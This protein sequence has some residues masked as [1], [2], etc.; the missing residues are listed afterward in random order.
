MRWVDPSIE[1]VLCGSSGNTM[2]TFPAWEETVLDHCYEQVDYLSLHKYIGDPDK[3][4]ARFLAESIGMDEFISTV[5]ATCDFVKAKKRSDKT[6][7]L[8]FDEWNVWYHSHSHDAALEPWSVAPV[9]SKIITLFSM[10]L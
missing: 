2:D 1:L 3:N 10:P 4:P 6:M 5:A 9:R 8:S 7:Y